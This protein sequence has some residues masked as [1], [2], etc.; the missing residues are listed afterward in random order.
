MTV[1]VWL[2]GVALC[3]GAGAAYGTEEWGSTAGEFDGPD[4]QDLGHCWL[5]NGLPEDGPTQ[6]WEKVAHTSLEER[7]KWLETN[8]DYKYNGQYCNPNY[9]MPHCVL[10]SSDWTSW[11]VQAALAAIGMVSLFLKKRREDHLAET[12]KLVPRTTK[13]WALDVS[14][15]A[16]SGACAH[17]LG[18]FN[19]STLHDRVEDQAGTSE[20]SWYLI[21]FT[22]DTTCGVAIGYILIRLCAYIGR[23]FPWVSA[24]RETGNYQRDG[25][26]DYCIWGQ[27]LFVWCIITVVARMAVLGIMIWA[28]NPLNAVSSVVAQEFACQPRTLLW[29]V[30]LA[31]PVTMNIIQLWVQDQFLKIKPTGV[32]AEQSDIALAAFPVEDTERGSSSHAQTPNR[33]A[34]LDAPL[35]SGH[36]EAR[37]SEEASPAPEPY[38]DVATAKEVRKHCCGWVLYLLASMFV[39][40]PLLMFTGVLASEQYYYDHCYTQVQTEPFERIKPYDRETPY[41]ADAWEPVPRCRLENDTGHVDPETQTKIDKTT[42]RWQTEHRKELTESHHSKIDGKTEVTYYEPKCRCCNQQDENARSSISATTGKYKNDSWCT[43][44]PNG[45][46]CPAVGQCCGRSTVTN[47]DPALQQKCSICDIYLPC[48]KTRCAARPDYIRNA[49]HYPLAVGVILSLLS[50]FYILYTWTFNSKLRRPT[51]TSLICLAAT[52]ELV[53]C[54]ALLMQEVSFRIPN[55]PCTN[56]VTHGGGGGGEVYFEDCEPVSQLYGWPNWQAVNTSNQGE[57][58]YRNG[59]RSRIAGQRGSAINYCKPMSF[60]FQLTWTASDSVYFMITVDL[61]LNLVSSPFGST[62][63]RWFLYHGWTWGVSFLFAILLM[64]SEDWGV[65]QESIL[66]DF[67]WNVNFGHHSLLQSDKA[68]RS[69]YP[70]LQIAV[71]CVSGGYYGLS[72]LMAAYAQCI[73]RRG[74]LPEGLKEARLESIK[75]GTFV[76]ALCASWLLFV[77]VLYFCVMDVATSQVTD[78]KTLSYGLRDYPTEEQHHVATKTWVKIWAF[79]W[80]ARNVINLIVWRYVIAQYSPKH[81][82]IHFAPG[83]FSYTL[84]APPPQTRAMIQRIIEAEIC[85]SPTVSR[86]RPMQTPEA[87]EQRY[88]DLDNMSRHKP[89]EFAALA[90]QLGV[91][92]AA[93][94]ELNEV[95]RN[96]LLFFVGLGIRSALRF[97]YHEHVERA[98]LISRSGR[99]SAWSTPN[100]ELRDD[101]EVNTVSINLADAEEWEKDGERETEGPTEF[102]KEVE[103]AFT[104]THTRASQLDDTEL[105]LTESEKDRRARANFER[106][107]H[108]EKFRFKTYEP[109]KF[110][111]LRELFG[112]DIRGG[113]GEDSELHKSMESFQVADFTGGASGAFMYFSADKRFIIKEITQKEMLRMLKMLNGYIKHLEESR[114]G[115]GPPRSLLQHVVQCNRITMSAHENCCGMRS[116][117]LYFMVMENCFYPRII[118]QMSKLHAGSSDSTTETRHEVNDELKLLPAKEKAALLQRLELNDRANQRFFVYDLKGSRHGRSTLLDNGRREQ[119]M[120]NTMKDNDLREN[121]HLST[122]DRAVVLKFLAKDSKFLEQQQ[123]MDYSLLLGVQKGI[124]QIST[125]TSGTSLGSSGPTTAASHFE[126]Y[127][128]AAALDGAETFYFGIIDFLQVC[129]PYHLCCKPA[130]CPLCRLLT[131]IPPIVVSIRSGI[132]GND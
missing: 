57:I 109:K 123:V 88:K 62:S 90:E 51:I 69:N 61:F 2:G 72:L 122:R 16:F 10:L 95:L 108:L 70:G 68:D 81:A 86:A 121:I 34:G 43:V 18:M 54:V 85:Q 115:D 84:R 94:L 46:S 40:V 7:K 44:T 129:R 48:D 20:C 15:Q 77:G 8:R 78:L 65:S 29:L 120:R 25:R 102:S 83:V 1:W 112:I 75:I 104:A 31:G 13:V 117:R 74:N 91:Q 24:L 27:Q 6:P 132:G 130:V 125:T 114:E 38:E 9:A 58:D 131:P 60:L 87:M 32:Q 93:N 26:I 99:G 92:E 21:A 14:K 53:Y 33:A 11:L 106:M 100:E 89:D 73:I 67:C 49:Q 4:S 39:V 56:V 79:V 35:L 80:G 50:N 82:E 98:T 113:Q 76:T 19:A 63:K 28:K 118:R 22:L 116:G 64:L 55:Q 124:R 96:E 12:R 110:R 103:A 17:V 41:S 45:L 23:K 37:A 47:P 107:Q 128:Q 42:L 5:V 30:M 111:R 59:K 126:Q 3:L 127:A 71:Y 52:I 66:E 101:G 105:E 97:P 36:A 119:Q